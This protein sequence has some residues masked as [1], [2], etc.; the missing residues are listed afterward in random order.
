MSRGPAIW[1]ASSLAIWAVI[2]AVGVLV[3]PWVG[4]ALGLGVWVATGIAFWVVAM[5]HREEDR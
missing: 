4:L 2:V 5:D 1:V 3:N